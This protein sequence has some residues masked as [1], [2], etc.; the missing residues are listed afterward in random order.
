MIEKMAGRSRKQKK[1]RSSSSSWSSGSSYSMSDLHYGAKL[2]EKKA[3]KEFLANPIKGYLTED[4]TN[5]DNSSMGRSRKRNRHSKK[6]QNA[7]LEMVKDE[8]SSSEDNQDSSVLSKKKNT[9]GR[10]KRAEK[11]RRKEIGQRQRRATILSWLIDCDVIQ[12]NAEVV[13]IEGETRKKQGRIQKEGILCS[14]CYNVFTVGDFY[15]HAGGIS[16]KHYEKIFIAETCS[17]LLSSMIQAWNLPE[18]RKF[19]RFNLIETSDEAS[20]SYDDACMICADGGDL[21]CCDKCSSTYHH[22][23]CLGMKVINQTLSLYSYF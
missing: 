19:H 20:D 21:M 22:E 1:Q 16:S 13:V 18:E 5:L 2:P 10:R 23:K 15:K 7:K 14:C 8:P 11:S 12:E 4:D 3:K 17:S 9:W 6:E